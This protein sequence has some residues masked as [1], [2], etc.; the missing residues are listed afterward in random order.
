MSNNHKIDTVADAL[1][2]LQAAF[3]D[4]GFCTT[5]DTEEPTN[6]FDNVARRPLDMR[7][8][9]RYTT[10]KSKGSTHCRSWEDVPFSHLL[11]YYDSDYFS[12]WDIEPWDVPLGRQ[13]NERL[14]RINMAKAMWIEQQLDSGFALMIAVEGHISVAVAYNAT[15][16]LFHNSFGVNEAKGGYFELSKQRVASNAIDVATFDTPWMECI[17]VDAIFAPKTYCKG[18]GYYEAKAE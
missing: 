7:R 10:F 9:L 16:L 13:W 18:C 15:H 12:K 1:D 11:M 8:S 4:L 3:T 14:R 6:V 17:D 5:V 2:A